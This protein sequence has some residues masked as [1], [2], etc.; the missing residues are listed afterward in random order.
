MTAQPALTDPMASPLVPEQVS[1]I[2]GLLSS[3]GIVMH[4]QPIV[5][6][7]HRSVFGLEAL[8]RGVA[9]GRNL[10]APSALFWLAEREGAMTE[11]LDACLRQ[12]VHNFRPLADR[13]PELT[14]FLNLPVEDTEAVRLIALLEELTATSRPSRFNVAIEVLEAEIADMGR[15]QSWIAELRARGYLIVL[16]DVGT[17]HSNL[18]RVPLIRPDVLKI[19]R[20]LIANVDKDA[21]KQGTVKTL[22]DLSR[23]IGALVIA[24]G[25]ETESEALV[26]LELGVDLLQGFFIERPRQY[27]TTD[28]DPL[29]GAVTSADTL[30]H[31]FRGYISGK[32]H[33]RRTQHQQF[34]MILDDLLHELTRYPVHEFDG[35]LGRAIGQYANV[36]SIYVLDQTGTQIT[37]TAWNSCV[38]RRLDS[39]PFRSSCKGTDHSL[40]DYCYL[41]HDIELPKY[42]TDPYVSLVGGNLIRTIS[43]GFTG[44]DGHH[45]VLCLDVLCRA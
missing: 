28:P 29:A 27:D 38:S 15:Y 23:T 8:A 21:H 40:K 31:R 24:E 5:S 7:R 17:G 6:V 2:Q 42:T 4:F 1:A 44:M 11:L 10:I 43:A 32:I 35:L 37:T 36:E 34:Q 30:A 45:C 14:L 3:G 18:D 22:V 26:A 9:I 13:V 39:F 12:T 19:D 41:L 25:I 16:D 20:T 33:E